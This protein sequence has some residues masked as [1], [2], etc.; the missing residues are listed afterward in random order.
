[1]THALSNDVSQLLVQHRLTLDLILLLLETES[2]IVLKDEQKMAWTFILR[3]RCR[4]YLMVKTNHMKKF[5]EIYS[6]AH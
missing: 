5:E 4:R 1:M 2:P 3:K 6:A